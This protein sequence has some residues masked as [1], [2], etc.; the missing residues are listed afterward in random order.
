[1]AHRLRPATSTCRLSPTMLTRT[2]PLS[3]TSCGGSRSRD[4]SLTDGDGDGALAAQLT[5]V[6]MARVRAA[7]RQVSFNRDRIMPPDVDATR[8]IPRSGVHA[9]DLHD[10][11]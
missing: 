8:Q 6:A 10:I 3:L 9:T 4:P 2:T 11:D 5:A 1:M 7:A